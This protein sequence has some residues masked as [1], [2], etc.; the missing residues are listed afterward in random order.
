MY[1]TIKGDTELKLEPISFARIEKEYI[2]LEHHETE[3]EI[4]IVSIVSLVV[5][6]EMLKKTYQ[7]MEMNESFNKLFGLADNRTGFL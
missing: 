1:K 6:L 5:Y 2:S 3:G 7:F 4:H